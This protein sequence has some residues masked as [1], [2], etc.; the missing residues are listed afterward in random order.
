MGM[1]C[2]LCCLVSPTLLGWHRWMFQFV[3][4]AIVIQALNVASQW[5]A[6][7]RGSFSPLP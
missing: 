7:M 2:E 5:A 4:L 1:I 6:A 3:P